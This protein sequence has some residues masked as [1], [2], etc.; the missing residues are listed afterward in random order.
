M[1]RP[2]WVRVRRRGKTESLFCVHSFPLLSSNPAKL[3]KTPFTIA[4]THTIPL[5]FTHPISLFWYSLSFPSLPFPFHLFYYK[6]NFTLN[7]FHHLSPSF[8]RQQNWVQF[9]VFM[10]KGMC[11]HANNAFSFF[12]KKGTDASCAGSSTFLAFLV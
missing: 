6:T 8:F 2:E 10:R 12:L 7:S 1:A 3:Y 4:I 5:R 9:Y 11:T